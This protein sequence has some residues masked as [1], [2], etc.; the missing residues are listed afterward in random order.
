LGVL[1]TFLGGLGGVE[2]SLENPEYCPK[3][4]GEGE[5]G[6]EG[7]E[8]SVL[9]RN[10]FLLGLIVVSEGP[11]GEEGE[12]KSDPKSSDFNNLE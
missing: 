2:H 11:A 9:N 1:G 7:P 10:I 5:N 12:A 4:E 6:E 3:I 8:Q